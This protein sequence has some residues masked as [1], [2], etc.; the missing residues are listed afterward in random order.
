MEGT[1]AIWWEAIRPKTLWA[2]VSPVLVG[3]SIAVFD[4]QV[5]VLSAVLALTGAVLIQIG[6]NLYND[7]ADFRKGADSEG[8]LGPRRMVQ[9]GLITE[10]AMKRATIAV[11]T[12]AVVSGIYLMWRGG[13]P[14]VLIGFCSILFG[15]A[16]TGGRYSLAYLGIAD[17]FVLLF[18]GPIAVA[19][20]YYVQALSWP[21]YVWIAGLAP[22]LLAVSILL[23]NNIRDREKDGPAGKKTLIVRRGR[24]VGEILYLSTIVGAFAVCVFLYVLGVA[25]VWTLLTFMSLPSMW[26]TYRELKAIPDQEGSLMNPVLARTARNLLVFSLL[27][28]AGWVMGAQG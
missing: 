14:I 24:A 9:T 5:H 13:I 23:V 6:T 16:Y 3:V 18:F 20:T 26:R 7:L 8:R 27:F 11:F 22:G 10:A 1:P 28:S 17:G 19:G 4:D 21:G 25:P 15:V 12:L 2:A